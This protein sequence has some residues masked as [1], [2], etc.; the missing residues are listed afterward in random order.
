MKK[1]AWSWLIFAIVV[2]YLEQM[3]YVR[4]GIIICSIW[5]AADAISKEIKKRG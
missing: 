3:E 5:S 4:L 1:W 2:W